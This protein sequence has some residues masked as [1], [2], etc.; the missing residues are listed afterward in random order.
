[1]I[2]EAAFK[3][4]ESVRNPLL[5]VDVI[6]ALAEALRHM[7]QIGIS[8]TQT[9]EYLQMI[10]Q[11]ERLLDT[12][13]DAEPL[14]VSKRAAFLQRYKGMLYRSLQE[15]DAAI[16]C[17]QQSSELHEE[18]GNK[19]EM[20]QALWSLSYVYGAKNDQ[21]RQLEMLWKVMELYEKM[22]KK[23]D[24]VQLLVEIASVY[25]AK[26]EPALAL[27]QAQ[28]SQAL[29]ETLPKTAQAGWLFSAIG[30]LYLLE[31][32]EWESSFA[33]QQ[34]ALT[35]FEEFGEKGGIGK[36][37]ARISQ[38]YWMF[39]G[40]LGIGLEFAEKA[41]AMFEEVGVK[42]FLSWPL[43]NLGWIAQLKGELDTAF[44]YH[45]RALALAEEVGSTL[46]I[47]E[48]LW[49]IGRVQQAKG[50]NNLAISTY[51]RCLKACEELGWGLFWS[52]NFAVS[53]YCQLTI[54][55]LDN[56]AI[57]EAKGY[58][59]QLKLLKE[60]TKRHAS[61][62]RLNYLFA[63]AMILKRST[64]IR[65]KAKA[66]VILHQMINDEKAFAL[67]KIPAMLNLCELLLFE[68][69]ASSD[70]ITEEDP[71]LEE[72]KTL[73]RNISSL[74]KE[75]PSYSL[76]VETLI[77]QSKFT[78][79]EGGLSAAAHYLDQARITAEEKE[80][81]VLAQK[82]A[83]E[84]QLLENQLDTWQGLIQSN[85]SFQTRLEQARF[86]DYLQDALKVAHLDQIRSGGS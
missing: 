66:Q 78:L 38:Y 4:S 13:T 77:L 47:A 76:L 74:A 84:Q 46:Y 67:F 45:E 59:Q 48:S 35:I 63:E 3:L 7:G 83:E 69:R 75:M 41:L 54:L 82:V 60:S 65:D 27:E 18:V 6:N 36:S 17:L 11:G 40:E 56:Q 81:P 33:L 5:K 43:N 16:Q 68:L 50:D 9:P 14:E 34:K 58:F 15:F 64:R 85:A 80:L 49:S 2:A 32:H 20:A 28:K 24:V 10:E 42:D 71:V 53:I 21:D 70:E 44:G 57:D 39:K 31:R 19:E 51:Q 55:T 72:V 22:E 79:I 52:T 73:I 61:W 12:I 26:G 25:H 86:A 29:A 37:F 1:E 8:H 23:E 30:D 62:T